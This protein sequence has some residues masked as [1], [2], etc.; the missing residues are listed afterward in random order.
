M[1]LPED[2]E[3]CPS[4]EERFSDEAYEEWIFYMNPPCNS[5]EM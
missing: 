2:Y 3:D 5:S 4:L 1:N